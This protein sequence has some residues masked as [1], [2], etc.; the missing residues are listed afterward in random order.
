[1]KYFRK[2]NTEAEYAAFKLSDDYVT[3]NVVLVNNNVDYNPPPIPLYIEA[4]EDIS[5]SFNNTYEYSKDG[6]TWHAGTSETSISATAGQKVHLR[7]SGLVASDSN[8]IGTIAVSNGTFNIGGNLISMAKGEE[9]NSIFAGAYQFAQLFRG[10][11]GLI[12]AKKLRLPTI[13]STATFYGLF[14]GCKNMV[15]APEAIEVRYFADSCCASMFAG[16]SS[17]VDP[18]KLAM[19]FSQNVSRITGS[20]SF[21]HMF[22]DCTSLVNAPDLPKSVSIN[23]SACQLMFKNCKSLVTAP[24]E[25]WIQGNYACNGMFRDCTSLIKSPTIYGGSWNNSCNYMFFG[26]TNL[27]Q[28]NWSGSSSPFC[29]QWVYGVSPTG[30]FFKDKGAT[31]ENTFGVDHIPEGWTVEVADA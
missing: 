13:I 17:L 2:F 30:T 16:C 19:L 7:A 8:G 26:C 21:S 14:S 27:S 5:I 10:N 28:I 11:D 12:S 22:Y 24:T 9:Y 4:I 29:T 31:W 6:N 23:R 18:P 3:P 15:S 1:M 25:V 20:D